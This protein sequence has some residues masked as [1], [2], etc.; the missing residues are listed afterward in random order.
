M[1]YRGTAAERD[2]FTSENLTLTIQ[3]L[4]LWNVSVAR[5]NCLTQVSSQKKYRQSQKRCCNRFHTSEED[6]VMVTDKVK[7]GDIIGCTGHPGKLTL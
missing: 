7:I 4:T 6:F 2:V 3:A 5:L 1:S